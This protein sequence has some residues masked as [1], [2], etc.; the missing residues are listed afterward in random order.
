MS[1]SRRSIPSV[2][3]VL[4]VINK[5]C[6]P[7]SAV[8]DTIR[9][10]LAVHRESG[11]IP[12][13]SDI[14]AQ[15]DTLLGE[16]ELSPIQ[17]VINGTGIIINTNLGRSPLG[18]DVMDRVHQVG[19]HYV[20][21]EI[22]LVEGKRCN[23][24]AYLERNLANLCGAEAATV[25]NN[26]AA[27]LLLIVHHFVS[28]DKNEVIISRGELIQIGGSFRIPDV[29]RSAGAELR[30]VGMTN[31]TSIEDYEG[32]INKNTALILKV[33]RS[34][35]FM[36]GFVQ[37]PSAEEI[38]HLATVRNVPYIEDLGSGAIAPTE[39]LAAIEHAQTPIESLAVGAD[40]VCFSGDKLLGGPQAGIIVGKSSYVADLKREPV[41]RALRCDK[42][43]LSAL[44]ATI[45]LYMKKTPQEFVPILAMLKLSDDE[46]KERAAAIVSAI[47]CSKLEAGVSQ[48]TARIGGGA[49]PRA[50]LN[51]VAVDL[52]PKGI[53]LDEFAR[54]L[55]TGMPPIFGYA[56][57]SCYKIDLRTVFPN[58]DQSLVRAIKLAVE[59]SVPGS[60]RLHCQAPR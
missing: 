17:P 58:Q 18:V 38:S 4:S 50:K 24:G 55:R 54:R 48:S 49:L 37:S 5:T 20:N 12:E 35:F 40:L 57:D 34:N 53:A 19:S 16:L 25:V 33:H 9:R 3:K 31:R 2:G 23:R 15:I 60:G 41:A 46:L 56:A 10:E 26:C 47:R 51:S 22:D 43:I 14:V 42:L 52:K 59:S 8:V 13:F 29:L 44:Q 32:A 21:L 1:T 11:D 39:S 6:L 36:E 7:R 28:Q 30:E 45:D 27:A